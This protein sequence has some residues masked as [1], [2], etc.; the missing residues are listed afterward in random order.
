ML[1][2]NGRCTGNIRKL[3]APERSHLREPSGN[4]GTLQNLLGE[5]CVKVGEMLLT[6]RM[7]MDDT[8]G[9]EVA[10]IRTMGEA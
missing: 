9:V 5:K 4:P 6:L 2:R 3:P 7:V 8:Y 1:H 10:K